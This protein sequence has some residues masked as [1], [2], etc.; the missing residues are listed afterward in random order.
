[1]QVCMPILPMWFLGLH[2]L[3][4]MFVYTWVMRVWI[5]MFLDMY[6]H[7]TMIHILI[8]YVW[9]WFSS[10]WCLVYWFAYL[11]LCD[12]YFMSPRVLIDWW[13]Q[14]AILEFTCLFGSICLLHCLWLQFIWYVVFISFP[15]G[16]I[17]IFFFDKHFPPDINMGSHVIFIDGIVDSSFHNKRLHVCTFFKEREKKVFQKVF[18]KCF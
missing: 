3:I 4:Y 1:M 18:Q 14:D 12:C 13:L 16:Y 8:E 9:M 6:I 2:V 10:P 11:Q 17:Y 15:S 7:E 5:Y